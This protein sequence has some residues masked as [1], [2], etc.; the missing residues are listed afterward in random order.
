MRVYDEKSHKNCADQHCNPNVDAGVKGMVSS[1]GSEQAG[2]G[3]EVAEREVNLFHPAA[4]DNEQPQ[5]NRRDDREYS[6]KS[7]CARGHS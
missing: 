1:G 2:G 3:A 5:Q 7:P 4:G 6:T